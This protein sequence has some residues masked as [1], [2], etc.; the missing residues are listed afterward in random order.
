MNDKLKYILKDLGISQKEIA[1]ILG[2]TQ[3]AVSQKIKSLSFSIYDIILIS[4][5]TG[6][7]IFYEIQ[8]LLPEKI[9][10]V[11]VHNSLSEV[12]QSIFTLGLFQSL[13]I[14]K[15]FVL[16]F[17]TFLLIFKCFS[18]SASLYDSSP[19]IVLLKYL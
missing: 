10:I 19:L 11:N 5:S 18:I 13:N 15:I 7:N 9:H 2:I 8:F 17:R 14:V 16:Y 3:S 12:E 6:K 4:N 1:S